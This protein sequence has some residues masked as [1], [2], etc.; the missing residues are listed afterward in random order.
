MASAKTKFVVGLFVLVGLVIIG[1][2]SIW[3]GLSHYLEGGKLYV[4]Y[5]DQSVQGLTRDS[6]VKYR[7]VSIGRVE[8]VRVAPD[9]YLIETVLKIET[10]LKIEENMVA[11]LK[12]IGITGI[13][14]I[15]LDRYPGDMPD[16]SPRITFKPGYP[17]IPT[18]PSV[19]TRF[20]ESMDTLL[21]KI[22]ALNLDDLVDTAASV[23]DAIGRMARET[24]VRGVLEQTDRTLAA[25]RNAI[26]EL[27]IAGLS[28]DLHRTMAQLEALAAPG[29]WTDTLASVRSAADAFRTLSETTGT[30]MTDADRVLDTLETILAENREAVRSLAAS[31]NRTSATADEFF[32]KGGDAISNELAGIGNLRHMLVRTLEQLQVLGENMNLLVETLSEHPSKLLLGPAPPRRDFGDSESE[33]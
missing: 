27:D 15:E 12:S 24:D 6:A 16:L 11:Q 25:V 20:M 13:M 29:R 31:L 10:D 21:K 1:T 3:L 17:V 19:I 8:S 28:G 18:R 7:G 26:E 14:F 33:R 5:F 22:E 9:G 32:K 2:A 23:I 30:T 4:A